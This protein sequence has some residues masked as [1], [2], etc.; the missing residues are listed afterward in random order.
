MIP[1]PGG[2]ALD[3]SVDL[4]RGPDVLGVLVDAADA[5]ADALRFIP[6]W[7]QP[8]SRPGQYLADQVADH[9]A[10][11]VLAAAG[12][13][14]V[15]EESGVRACPDGIVV[16]LDPLD[17]SDNAV[18]GSGP[19][20]VSLCAVDDHGPLAAVV[21]DL[22]EGAC[23]TAVRGRGARRDGERIATSGRLRL[24]D[25]VL[26]TS[27]HPPHPVTQRTRSLGAAAIEVCGVADGTFDAFIH[28]GADHH[29]CW[30]Y[31]GGLLIAGEAGGAAADTKG[32]DLVVL[33][34]R[35]RRAPM[36]AA[37]PELLAAL[38]SALAWQGEAAATSAVA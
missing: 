19:F 30:D 11:E 3:V 24:D 25:A 22:S 20:G 14:V 16:A 6:V 29:G 34:P 4:L 18:R 27:G 8:G 15:S 33:D 13:G 28:F 32:R 37:T 1:P 23:Y 17:G 35:A 21:L 2:R 26:A 31:L 12:L 5:V 36:V 7:G 10:V 9:A 38:R